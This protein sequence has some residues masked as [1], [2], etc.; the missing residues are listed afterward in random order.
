MPAGQS[1]DGRAR[2][3]GAPVPVRP[4]GRG[5][6]ELMLEALVP[7]GYHLLTRRQWPRTRRA[8]VDV[9][10]IGPSGVFV[11][12]W[13][14]GADVV[15]GEDLMLRGGDD[16]AGEA[17][18]LADLADQVEAELVETGLAPGEVRSV[19]ALGARQGVEQR[20]GP[21]VVVGERDLLRVVV[22]RGPRLTPGE[23]DAVLA[24]ALA[25]FP[26]EQDD[27]D[28]VLPVQGTALSDEEVQGALLEGL[29]ASPIEQ[30]M[31][32]CE[33]VQSRLVRRSFDGPALVR[34][35]VG[36][37]KTSVGL[38]RAAYLARNRPGRVLVATFT[39][40]QPPVL[41]ELLGRLA[42]DVADRIDVVH[43]N[44]VA[45]QVLDE[46]KVPFA[47]GVRQVAS[48]WAAAWARAGAGTALDPMP[49]GSPDDQGYW[50]DEVTAVI[51]GRG[52]TRFDQYA[53]LPRLG[54]LRPLG[55][56]ERRAVW[57]VYVAY[58]E[59]LVARDVGD[60]ADL[61]ALAGVHLPRTSFARRYDAVLVDDAQHLSCSALAML[62]GLVGDRPDGLMLLG[63]AQQGLYPG[64]FT[65]AEAGIDVVGRTVTLT[66][67]HRTTTEILTFAA[68]LVSGEQVVG[69]DGTLGEAD[70]PRSVPR[71]G[72]KPVYVR[73]G[74][75]EDRARRA[76]ARVKDVVQ[77]VGTGYGDVGVLC[78][79]IRG[80]DLAIGALNGVGIPV[81]LLDDDD[82]TVP[83]AVRV[84]TVRRAAGLEFRQVVMPDV[85]TSWFSEPADLQGGSALEHHRL[86]MRELYVAMTRARDG[87]WVAGV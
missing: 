4:S 64:G 7:R 66:T 73:C 40:T 28:P 82:R 75:D 49:D 61:V 24:R 67:A 54:R 60:W 9:L 72:P 77:Q 79:T 84:G 57:D 34:G 85:D 30:W 47:T 38:H 48:A 17:L 25:S 45:R 12:G 83:D 44:G 43:V 11:V 32:F 6:V 10:V 22:G 76:V 39:R 18:A 27:T 74:T 71:H 46:A 8:R 21:V 37:G 29:L 56:D 33:P 36:T 51:K 14:D 69:L 42:P 19:L 52:L 78:L 41:T 1:A 16:A 63:D 86:R 68:E 87:L 65:P 80:M 59:E 81:V 58:Q 55:P 31:A 70:R 23:V 53:A 62:H 13:V 2:R 15:V 5:H 50:H 20:V 35:A 3:R 26:A